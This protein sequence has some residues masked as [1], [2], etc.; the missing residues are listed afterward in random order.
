MNFLPIAEYELRR[1]LRRRGFYRVRTS[2]T[3]F[4]SFL[5]ISIYL[6]SAR[7][8]LA[9][10]AAG[11]TLF[12]LL[13]VLLL[14]FCLLAGLAATAD[15]LSEE[16]R[17]GTLGFLFLTPL[18]GY[19]VVLG[20]LLGSSLN[21]FSGLLGV[22]PML[23]MAFLSGGVAP[24][25]F[26]RV[27]LL[28]VNTLWV[29]LATGIFVSAISFSGRKAI[30]GTFLLL[31]LCGAAAAGG[32]YWAS[33][34]HYQISKLPFWLLL[35]VAHLLGWGFF[36]LACRFISSNWRD[37]PLWLRGSA[38]SLPAWLAPSWCQSLRKQL[39]AADP[40]FWLGGRDL[41]LI[42]QLWAG[43]VA[44]TVVCFLAYA[45]LYRAWGKT[46]T[47]CVTTFFLHA[48][49]KCLIALEAS[50]GASEERASGLLELL[51]TAPFGPD[52]VVQG[53]L[54][55][56]KRLFAGPIVMV[57]VLDLLLFVLS[58]GDF[59]PWSFGFLVSVPIL[60]LDAYS[61]SWLGLYFGVVAKNSTRAWCL[62]MLSI[63]ALP[64]FATVCLLTLVAALQGSGSSGIMTS[65]MILGWVGFSL[66]ADLGF[67]TWAIARLRE[68]VSALLSGHLIGRR[69][70][71]L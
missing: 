61:L 44:A 16:K 63:L 2:A 13:S 6:A 22:L 36:A 39:L 62:C 24:G 31:L 51:L 56:I 68:I 58:L 45:L 50:R 48:F 47:L 15:C 42:V 5:A 54:V 38:W 69:G 19:D 67:C 40:R 28:L 41:R 27:S 14:T 17:E 71:S 60:L 55:L 49:L 64:W 21:C 1:A 7:A 34:F 26:W 12:Q 18:R 33:D 37:N 57:L 32:E 11:R 65:W 9:P 29:S 53:R 46:T 30:A 52:T 25:E 8:W 23:A 70:W 4:A 3:A 43:A 10:T 59:Q 35:A 20:K 66:M